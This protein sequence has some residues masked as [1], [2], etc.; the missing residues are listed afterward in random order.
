MKR[1]QRCSPERVKKLEEMLVRFTCDANV[2]ARYSRDI[3][4]CKH[5]HITYAGTE[6]FPHEYDC[7]VLLARDLLTG[8]E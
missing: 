2:L 7:P 8:I 5:C 3:Y 4:E 6:P 1:D